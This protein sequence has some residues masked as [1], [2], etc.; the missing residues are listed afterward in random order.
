MPR[1]NKREERTLRRRGEAGETLVEI[2][3]SVV[4]VGLVMGAIF[5]TYATAATA[6]KD[7]RDFATVDAVLRNY[8]EAAKQATNATCTSSNAG[9]PLN[10]IYVPPGGFKVSAPPAELICPP[11]K[12]VGQLDISATT[13][14]GATHSLV[15]DVRTP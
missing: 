14:G 8:A 12:S 1:C 5:A 13:P 7:G 2:L 4:I 11:L 6:S 9:S 15:V 10:V 3:I